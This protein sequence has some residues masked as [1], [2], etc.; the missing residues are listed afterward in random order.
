MIT[1]VTD[2]AKIAKSWDKINT[3]S[4][5]L[6]AKVSE[7]T[8]KKIPMQKP[9]SS[10]KDGMVTWFVSMPFFQ[11]NFL[12]SVTLNDK[13]F[14]A[15][16]SKV[17]AVDLIGKAEAGGES[18]QGVKFHVNFK[19]LGDYSDEMFKVV[20]RRMELL[21]QDETARGKFNANKA[22]IKKMIDATREFDSMTWDVRKE[23]GLVRSR[24]HFK[25]N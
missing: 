24:I 2:R 21:I 3:H 11:D 8:Q 12:P 5:A 7:M 16:T 15:S 17:Q 10:E 14:V 23:D 22:S 4:T 20:D 19:V 9:I 13:W 18:G 25:M 1:P 6:L